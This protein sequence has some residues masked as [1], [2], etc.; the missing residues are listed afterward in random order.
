MQKRHTPYVRRPLYRAS[1]VRLV[2]PLDEP[3][4]NGRHAR[5]FDYLGG[6]GYFALRAAAARRPWSPPWLYG[7][8][9]HRSAP[10]RRHGAQ[11]FARQ[12]PGRGAS[13]C[14]RREQGCGNARRGRVTRGGEGAIDVTPE[15]GGARRG[16]GGR[17]LGGR[18][19]GGVFPPRWFLF[20]KMG[21]P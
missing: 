2:W 12:S 10:V 21:R 16:G 17:F 3:S 8:S 19:W 20:E 11:L 7:W 1:S 9:S 4:G 6:E 5:P 13:I 14:D 15:K 18:G